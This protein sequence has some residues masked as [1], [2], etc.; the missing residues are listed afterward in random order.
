MRHV[1]DNQ[2]LGLDVQGGGSSISQQDLLM[3]RGLLLALKFLPL[4]AT[5]RPLVTHGLGT[6]KKAGCSQDVP[7]NLTVRSIEL[8]E[9]GR[10]RC[11]T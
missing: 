5:I 10:W 9:S 7:A 3:K 6:Q 4:E 8:L 1:L 11:L 2:H